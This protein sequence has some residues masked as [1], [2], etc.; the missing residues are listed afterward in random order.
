MK[1]KLH[2]RSC[3]WILLLLLLVLTA[4][5]KTQN[6]TEETVDPDELITGFENQ[7]DYVVTTRPD[8]VVYRLPDEKSE[9]Y[10]T[11]NTGVDLKRTGTKDEW[12]RIRLNDTSLYIK[13]E[14][15]KK[16]SI[17]WVKEQEK[18]ENSHVVFIDPA[19]QI[20]ADK[21]PESLFP[22]GD[23]EKEG[24]PRMSSAYIGTQTGHFEYDVTMEVAERLKKEL[25]LRGYTVILSRTA[26]T[27]SISNSERAVAGNHS[28]AEIM[29]RLTAAGSSNKET[30][31]VFGLI[32]SAK[33]PTNSASYQDSF[34]LANSMVT[35][36]CTCTDATRLGIYQT[37][38]MVFLNYAKKPTA[39]IQLGFLSNEEEDQNL[40]DGTYQEKLAEGL[41]NGVDSY[42]S[43]KDGQ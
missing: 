7:K 37:D 23:A 12:T 9:V 1:E 8:S 29:I 20:Y 24:K 40:S 42:F 2:I 38:K 22:D 43:F 18:K 6:A 19:K 31:G 33:N 26:G 35:E 25:E 39:V 41:A 32:A 21:T 30:K 3:R 11:L 14:N 28:D 16:T 4:C 17:E 34:Y 15:V 27:T 10:I 5:G 36:T 13:S